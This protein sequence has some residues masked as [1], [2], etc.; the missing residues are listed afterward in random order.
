M[1]LLS[2]LYCV[3]RGVWIRW[4]GTVEWN[5][6]ME[7]WNGA[8]VRYTSTLIDVGSSTIRSPTRSPSPSPYLA[9]SLPREV[10]RAADPSIQGP[11]AIQQGCTQE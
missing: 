2:V 4:N 6:G 8:F 1:S 10:T 5:G 3:C 11:Q 9:L 7:Y